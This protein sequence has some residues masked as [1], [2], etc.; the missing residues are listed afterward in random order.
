MAKHV[1]AEITELSKAYG[2]SIETVDDG[3]T[4]PYGVITLDR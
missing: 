1:L 3:R 2:T 4:S